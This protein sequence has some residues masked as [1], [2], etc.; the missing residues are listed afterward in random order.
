MFNHDGGSLFKEC[1]VEFIEYEE[2]GCSSEGG[3]ECLVRLSLFEELG[4][5]EGV[6][7]FFFDY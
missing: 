1:I 3:Q 5:G 6:E 7:H 2:G 4:G